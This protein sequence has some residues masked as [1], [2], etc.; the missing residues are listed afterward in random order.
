VPGGKGTG[1]LHDR[2]GP[3]QRLKFSGPFGRF[4]VRKSDPQPIIF[5]AGGSGLSSPKSMLSDLLE[6]GDARQMTLVYGARN[7]EELYYHAFFL[8]LSERHPNFHYV[9]ALS[10]D[11]E[12]STWQGHRGFVHEAAK[13]HFGNDFRGH[14]AYLC[15]PPAMIE[16]T[17]RTLMQ[18][19][20]FERDIH[21][22]KFLTNAD[23][24]QA[25]AKSPLFR[26]L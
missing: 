18:G 2:L 17:I 15:G 20:L 16:A 25:L 7:R 10:N 24:S 19:Q 14:R 12:G 5:I 8:E 21:T 9:P 26:S 23:G 4:F 1:Y 6:Q 22:E 3:G 11:P 13:A